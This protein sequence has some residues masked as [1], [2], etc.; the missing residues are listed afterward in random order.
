MITSEP[1]LQITFI[2]VLYCWPMLS[3]PTCNCTPGVMLIKPLD[4]STFQAFG[5]VAMKPM[6][7]SL[8]SLAIWM[9]ASVYAPFAMVPLE[10]ISARR[11]NPLF[12]GKPTDFNPSMIPDPGTMCAL[13]TCDQS[14]ILC[15][16]EEYCPTTVLPI[17]ANL[18]S[19]KMRKSCFFAIACNF[20]PKS[21]VKSGYKSQCVFNMQISGP[22]VS[23]SSSNSFAVSTSAAT[24]KFD[25]FFS[26][27]WN[28]SFAHWLEAIFALSAYVSLF[29]FS[30]LG[31]SPPVWFAAMNCCTS[32]TNSLLIFPSFSKTFNTLLN[33]NTACNF[34]P[35]FF[36]VCSP[37]CSR[38]IKTTTSVVF[39]P[40]CCNGCTVSITDIPLVTKS[41]TNKHVCPFSNAPSIAFF[42]P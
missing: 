36:N 41:S 22:N 6:T 32:S 28:I 38:S 7:K 1:L 37:P 35:F 11:S 9:A 24:H 10:L 3:P 42:V 19:S 2:G 13:V 15:T 39:N 31:L 29:V 23:A 14:A 18:R 16:P 12:L 21:S 34:N 17:S 4:H 40:T 30:S 33:G 5:F 27:K 26:I 20:S 25:F 8:W